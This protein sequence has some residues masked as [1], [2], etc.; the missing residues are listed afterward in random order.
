[1]GDAPKGGE[2][3]ILDNSVSGWTGSRYLGDWCDIAAGSTRHAR[4]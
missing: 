2:L 1:M 3:F 4:F